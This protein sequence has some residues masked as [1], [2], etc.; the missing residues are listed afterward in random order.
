MIEGKQSTSFCKQKEVLRGKRQ[1]NF[2]FF[3]SKR[4]ASVK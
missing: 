1:K 4:T 2:W 3:F